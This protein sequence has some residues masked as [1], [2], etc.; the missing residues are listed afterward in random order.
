M[1]HVIGTIIKNDDE[2]LGKTICHA[3]SI[4]IKN[5]VPIF[6]ASSGLPELGSCP[7][8]NFYVGLFN[9]FLINELQKEYGWIPANAYPQAC[10]PTDNEF[11]CINNVKVIRNDSPALKD[12]LFD[13]AYIGYFKTYPATGISKV[14]PLQI[15]ESVWVQILVHKKQ[16]RC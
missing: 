12:D 11:W 15:P 4:L 8:R 6:D 5:D 16:C 2:T 7:I 3:I 9:G 10:Q 13:I 1:K 14:D